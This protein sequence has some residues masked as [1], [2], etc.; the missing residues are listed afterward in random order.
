MFKTNFCGHDTIWG[1]Q[2]YLGGTAPECPRGYGPGITDKVL[3]FFALQFRFLEIRLRLQLSV[4]NL[5]RH[6]PFYKQKLFSAQI[7]C[8]GQVRLGIR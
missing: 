1:A 2:K 8:G 4:R 3:V 5:L 6:K 7:V